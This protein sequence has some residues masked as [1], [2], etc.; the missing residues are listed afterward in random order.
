MTKQEAAKLFREKYLNEF[1]GG[2]FWANEPHNEN[3]ILIA[4]YGYLLLAKNGLLLPGDSEKFYSA[5][6]ALEKEPGLFN[7]NPND[8][9]LESMDN[10]V[11]MVV[12][13]SLFGQ[14]DLI[15]DIV[16]YGK[17]HFWIYDNT[18][19]GWQLSKECLKRKLAAMRQP[20]EVAIYKLC[21]GDKPGFISGPWLQIGMPRS[22]GG[23]LTWARIEGLKASGMLGLLPNDRKELSDM[24]QAWLN[25]WMREAPLTEHMKYFQDP[26]HPFHVLAEGLDVSK[27]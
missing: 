21:N 24:M 15:E 8:S 18:G 3:A 4:V 6:K 13:A 22:K 16:K 10:T 27:E 19:K 7:R 11:A 12:G 20:G 26:N 23:L 14:H 25:K 1:G 2:M 17:K 9:M 5:C